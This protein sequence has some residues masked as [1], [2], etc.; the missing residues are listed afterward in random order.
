[1]SVS[2]VVPVKKEE[3]CGCSACADLCPK[4][5]I[6][7]KS[8]EEG[9]LYPSVNMEN[10]TSCGLCIENCAFANKKL[11]DMPN[12]LPN[13]YIA[14][15]RNESVRL[16]SAS[17]GI[18]VACSDWILEQGGIVYGCVLNQ[19]FVAVHVRAENKNQRNLMCKSKYVQSNT[20]KVFPLV[21]N[22]LRANLKVLFS[23]TGCQIDGLLSYLKSKRV[24]IENLYTMD[25]I[26]YGCP[27]PLLFSDFIMWLK[28][29]YKGNI[30]SFVFRDKKICGWDAH[31]ES[32][33]ISG[34]KRTGVKWRDLF[35][36][37]LSLRPSCYNCKYSTVQHPADITMGDA[38]G[39]NQVKPEFDD[40]R[41]V[42]IFL[43]NGDKGKELL[44]IIKNNCDV[45]ELPLERPFLQR[46]Q[47]LY[48][49]HKPRG[50]RDDFWKTYYEGG[51]EL[52]IQKYAKT[53]IFKKLKAKLRYF[54]KKL[55]YGRRYYLP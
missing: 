21:E 22:D 41:G 36:C 50:N 4:S 26:C 37:N 30:S 23:G 33:V 40:N 49:P 16:N 48:S 20:C 25:V 9:F 47:S 5:A 14:K 42:S 11:P 6:E 54:K 35:Y 51:I 53:K 10:C 13:C 15:H 12:V 1:M 46:N 2:K 44:Q 18:F 29:K 39:I 55:I 24:N 32:A 19:D 27:S 31:I 38:W 52:L 7:M 34:K 43:T 8:D 17:G 28:K 45:E 3:C